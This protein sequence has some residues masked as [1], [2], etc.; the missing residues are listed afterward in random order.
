MS[1]TQVVG[2]GVEPGEVKKKHPLSRWAIPIVLG[3][4]ASVAL[5][6][7]LDSGSQNTTASMRLFG[8]HFV[9]AHGGSTTIA[10]ALMFFIG[11]WLPGWSLINAIRTPKSVFRSI[12]RSKVLWVVALVI[13]FLVADASLVLVSLY[14]LLRVRPQLNNCKASA[15]L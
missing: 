10:L 3:I 13:V 14:Y 9:V 7:L 6:L 2:S 8:H 15:R 11:L 1:E 5:G 12:G 4:V